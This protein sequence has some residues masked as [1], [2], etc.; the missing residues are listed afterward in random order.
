MR[1]QR[2]AHQV[3]E[4]ASAEALRWLVQRQNRRW[5]WLEGNKQRKEGDEMKLKWEPGPALGSR[6]ADSPNSALGL[7]ILISW[8]DSK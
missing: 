5:A 7:E 2:L 8:R 1:G 3:E 4:T 6:R